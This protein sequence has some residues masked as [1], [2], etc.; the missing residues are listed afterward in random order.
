VSR[1]LP[2]CTGNRATQRPFTVADHTKTGSW[3]YLPEID[4][5]RAIAI[6]S[7]LI[8]HF[9]R[10]VFG[11][12]FVGVD[13]FFV[14]SGFLITSI[15]LN[16]INQGQFSILRFYQRRIAR[17]A[18][19]FFV[20]LVVTL[21]AA[22]F[23]YSAQDFASLGANS[24][25]A[26]LSAINL[27]LLFQGTYF[28]S[29]ADAQAILHYWSLSVE[30]QFYLFFPL[31]LYVVMRFARRPLAVTLTV[32][33]ASFAAC[34][35][36]TRFAPTYAFYLL[37]T[38][39]WELLMGAGLALF[40][41]RGGSISE[42]AASLAGWGGLAL[43]LLALLSIR[44]QDH[45][46]GWIAMIPVCGTSLVLASIQEGG[47]GLVQRMLAQR[48]PV[49]I[50]KRSYS[51]YLWHWPIFSLVDYQFY[52]ASSSLRISLKILVCIVATL[53]SYKF[54]ERPLRAYLSVRP[55]RSLAFGGFALA[56]IAIC[57]AGT[58]IR[59]HNYLS[60][61]L[62][63]IASGGISIKG[64]GQGTVALVGD[65][66]AAM[67]GKEL[68]SIARTQGFS[69]D[70]LGAAATNELP[71]EPNTHWT[72]VEKYLVKRR[73]DVVIVAE[74]WASKLEGDARDLRKA[75][76]SM[77]SLGSRVILVTEP[78]ILPQP[79]VREAIRNGAAPSFYENSD[80]REKRLTANATVRSLANA[81]VSVLDI[82]DIFTGDGG[83]IQAIAR[84][85]RSN[86][87]DSGHLSDSGTA[88]VRPVLESAIAN[89][90]RAR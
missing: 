1:F 65:S 30:E 12:G 40:R 63:Q 34:V 38:R 42:R 75:L 77:E 49:Y 73:P 68:A 52:S 80:T 60:A 47:G 46:P 19:A 51:L 88:L 22:Y 29:S 10:Q 8:F 79:D 78:P 56:M 71:D 66:Q 18:P 28:Q 11:G 70:V 76:D 74:A 83:A 58:E 6:L 39:A 62:K 15:L 54:V 67:Y 20:V 3:G 45:F 27:K 55:R 57:V 48:L 87:H 17:I 90:L 35:V 41:Q 64:T 33:A 4:G 61:D 7:V 50:G 37:P 82:D 89:A 81:K 43:L 24:L 69:L 21:L 72:D 23:V 31:Y 59:M 25:A 13:I 32:G 9:N 36:V 85:G 44:P 14:I 5:L 2:R 84:N 26:A 86:Y 16:D 53:L